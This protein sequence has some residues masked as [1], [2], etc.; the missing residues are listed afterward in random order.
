MIDVLID[1]HGFKV[2]LVVE[3]MFIF[4]QM[5]TCVLVKV[6]LFLAENLHQ[7]RETNTCTQTRF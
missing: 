3:I 1:F 7:E 4:I 6:L 2:F 5:A